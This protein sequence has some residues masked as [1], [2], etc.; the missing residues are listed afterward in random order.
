MR[1]LVSDDYTLKNSSSN[2]IVF[3]NDEG[4]E[5]SI[6]VVDSHV[7]RVLHTLPKDKPPA[8]HATLYNS[9]SVDY[10]LTHHLCKTNTTASPSKAAI[11]L[12]TNDIQ[13]AITPSPF[14][15][16]WRKAPTSS[17]CVTI[18]KNQENDEDWFA[19]DLAYRSYCYDPQHGTRWHYQRRRTCGDNGTTGTFYYGLGERT[20]RL[21][22]EGRR[23]SLERM[24]A[25][26]YDAETQGPMYKFCPFYVGLASSSSS[27]TEAYGVY[28]NNF[29]RTLFDLGQERDAVSSL[30]LDDLQKVM[31][32]FFFY[33]VFL[34]TD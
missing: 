3:A 25:M 8:T 29:S 28:Y 34:S 10:T 31:L 12:T 14:S 7:I 5:I 21:N 2:P 13:L 27:P 30:L 11:F 22:L 24:D 4:H 33:F 15:I 6:Y 18:N 1:Q 19:Q 16:T 20:G 9:S 17:T 23:F 26:G 32:M